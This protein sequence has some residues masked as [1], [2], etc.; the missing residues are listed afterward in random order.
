MFK[1]IILSI[2]CLLM[3]LVGC[4]NSQN[5]NDDDIIILFTNDTHGTIDDNFGFESIVGYKKQMEKESK[6]V[7]LVDCGDEIQGTYL[8]TL[9]KGEIGINV[10]NLIGYKYAA[11]G[12]HEFDYGNERLRELIDLSNYQFLNANVSYNGSGTNPFEN[13]PA[14]AIDQYGKYKVAFIGVTTPNTLKE[15]NPQLFRENDKLVFDFCQGENDQKFINRIQETVDEVKSKGSD[16]VVLMAHVGN[17]DSSIYKSKNIAEN[18]TGIDVI[19]DG[20]SHASY[21]DEYTN[22]DGK[23]VP[24]AQTGTMLE[25]IGKATIHTDGSI[26]VELIDTVMS[27]DTDIIPE[28]LKLKEEYDLLINGIIGNAPKTLS[29]C[30]E[31]GTRIVRSRETGIGDLCADAIRDYYSCD[32]AYVNGG[33]VRADIEEGPI[34][35]ADVISVHTFGNSI[36]TTKV[37]GQEIVDMLEYW[38]MDTKKDYKDENGNAIGESG[39][40]CCISGVRF[41]LNLDIEPTVNIDE[42]GNLISVGKNRRVNDV[43]IIENGEYVPID[44]NKTYV[45]GSSSYVIMDGGSGMS[46]YLKDHEVYEDDNVVDYEVLAHYIKDTLKGTTEK[47]NDVDGRITIK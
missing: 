25:H 33:G 6:Y 37:T 15:E 19:I 28:L 47:Y 24:V 20:H 38:T 1:K 8:T 12:N 44:L 18:T 46:S 23:T 27:Q 17:E 42:N 16:Y 7:T 13:V 21:I 35:Y 14:Y 45:F 30:D 34:T 32:F 3:L 41:N 9:S 39:S 40:F 4:S 2:A 10:L 26:N 36:V 5:L 22:L 29:I 11:L 43:Q 31:N